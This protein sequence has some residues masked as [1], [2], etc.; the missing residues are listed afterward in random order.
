MKPGCTGADSVNREEGIGYAKSESNE[1]IRGKKASVSLSFFL[2][3]TE[4]LLVSGQ[5]SPG[6]LL[7]DILIFVTFVVKCE[8]IFQPISHI[9][10]LVG[11]DKNC[12]DISTHRQASWLS[13]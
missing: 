2:T 3:H 11:G 13:P 1:E 5:A 6:T 4:S 12:L 9:N 8:I 10:L 7:F